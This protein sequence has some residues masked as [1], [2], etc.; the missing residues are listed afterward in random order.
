MSFSAQVQQQVRAALESALSPHDGRVESLRVVPSP[1]Q[2]PQG[3][4]LQQAEA[5]LAVP[6]VYS[7]TTDEGAGA[8]YR[9][10]LSELGGRVAAVVSEW[11]SLRR[12]R[13]ILWEPAPDDFGPPQPA[14]RPDLRWS[15]RAVIAVG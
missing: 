7:Y 4:R 12:G 1:V 9:E 8:P 3:R 11:P 10:R 14:T 13:L 2:F 6:V 15:V 5:L